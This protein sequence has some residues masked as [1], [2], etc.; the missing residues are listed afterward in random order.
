MYWHILPFAVSCVCIYINVYYTYC[1]LFTLGSIYRFI[2]N[3]C[4]Y[5]YMI[6][7]WHLRLVRADL[8]LCSRQ[9]VCPFTP[10]IMQIFSYTLPPVH[11]LFVSSTNLSGIP[12]ELV[13]QLTIFTLPHLFQSQSPSLTPSFVASCLPLLPLCSYSQGTRQI[14]VAHPDM[15]L[16]TL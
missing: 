13:G 14:L 6:L 3:M 12:W 8:Q 4:L 2:V 10:Q 9:P 1:I 16:W 5:F 15:L 7:T 11:H